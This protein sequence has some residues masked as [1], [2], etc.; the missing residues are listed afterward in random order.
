M[1]AQK[2]ILIS[3]E[4]Y[5]R[6]LKGASETKPKSVTLPDKAPTRKS[7]KRKIPPPPGIPESKKAKRVLN[8]KR[9]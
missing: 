4:R 3:E 1:E 6:L 8:M 7:A 2:M 5:N 9:Y